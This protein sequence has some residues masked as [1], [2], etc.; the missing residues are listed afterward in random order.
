MKI[1]KIQVHVPIGVSEEILNEST[2]ITKEKMDFTEEN[3]NTKIPH[4]HGKIT[5]HRLILFHPTNKEF[6]FEWH[7][8]QI[9]N[10]SIE[11][12]GFFGKYPYKIA[13]NMISGHK[14]KVK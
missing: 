12:R 13:L 11:K 7:Y 2:Y 1:E 5:T 3:T 4:L 14:Y 10:Y 9:R 8:N 6:N